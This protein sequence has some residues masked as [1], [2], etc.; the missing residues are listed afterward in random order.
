MVR[1]KLLSQWRKLTSRLPQGLNL[2]TV[3]QIIEDQNTGMN[4][5]VTESADNTRLPGTVKK[6]LVTKHTPSVS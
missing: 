2:Q 5:K 1:N 4:S 6:E 3:I